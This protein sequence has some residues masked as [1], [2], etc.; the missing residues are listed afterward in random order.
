MSVP[1]RS[2]IRSMLA[3]AFAATV[4]ASGCAARQHR[5]LDQARIAYAEAL[6]DP[7]VARYAPGPLE[8]AE[9]TLHR[10]EAEYVEG[11]DREARHLS[12]VTTQEVARARQI[13]AEKQ[14]R[15]ETEALSDA[16]KDVVLAAREQELSAVLAE[17]AALKARETEQGLAL[18]VSDVFFEFDR[19]DLKPGAKQDLARVARFLQHNP[20]RNVVIEG[21]TD[22]LGT[23]GYNDELSRRRAL[24]VRSYLV[25]QGVALSRLTS[26]GFGESYP[27]ASNTS[28]AGREQNRRVE[29]LVLNPG[30]TVTITTTPIIVQR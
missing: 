14:A 28:E 18:T 20:D 22:S 2:P 25:A 7:A 19:A 15:V 10:A 13:A 27:V 12:Y 29:M 11:N 23:D 9:D 3:L 30:R 4:A 6:G 17:L 21:H 26:Q 16:R 5:E 1:E 8:Q 24:A